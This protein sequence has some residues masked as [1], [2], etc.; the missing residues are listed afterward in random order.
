MVTYCV[1]KGNNGER[2]IKIPRLPI[3]RDQPP[4]KESD[5]IEVAFYWTPITTMKVVLNSDNSFQGN[6]TKKL[7]DS[8]ILSKLI[9]TPFE[10]KQSA[11][12]RVIPYV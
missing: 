4:S 10:P 8:K 12:L 1:P 5:K 3:T 9:C 7:T 11:P 6:R 2:T